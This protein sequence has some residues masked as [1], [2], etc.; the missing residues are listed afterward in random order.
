M[1]NLEETTGSRRRN[2]RGQGGLLRDDILRAAAAMIEETGSE[3][4]VT[5]RSVARE[6]GIA[7]PSI[8]AHFPDRD[9]ILGAVIDEAF[10]ELSAAV[11]AAVAAHADPVDRLLAGCRA[12]VHFGTDYPGRYRVLFGRTPQPDT[13]VREAPMQS[14]QHLVDAVTGAAQAGRSAS[15]DP[16]RD[17]TLV[18]T[19]MHGIISLRAATPMFPWPALDTVVDELVRRLAQIR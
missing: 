9:A 1:K 5:L 8:Y 4:A 2:R 12:Y 7:A 19:G 13:P 18:W 6:V 15:T 14:F 11:T 3:E 16:F 10:G 17:A